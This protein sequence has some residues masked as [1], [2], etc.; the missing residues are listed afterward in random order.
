MLGKDCFLKGVY[1]I[2]CTCNGKYYIGST[3]ESFSK[4]ISHHVSL[5][6]ANKHKNAHMQRCFNKYG[7]G[8]FVFEILKVLKSNILDEEQVY[9]DMCISDEKC[10]NINPIAS[11]TPNLSKEVIKKRAETMRRKYA[12]GEMESNFKKGHIPWNKGKSGQYD[13]TYLKKPKTL[14]KKL[15]NSRKQMSEERRSKS[16]KIFAYSLYGD[17]LGSWR[18]SKDLEEWSL[19]KN[20]LLPIMSRFKQEYRL[21]KPFNFLSSQ[22]ITRSANS[23][24]PYKGIYFTYTCHIEEENEN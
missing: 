7:E 4:R 13:T 8:S 3:H 24:K 21:G 12:M 14:T 19:S 1:K 11:G 20:N 5:L 10:F 23:G 6:R 16:P 15:V 22:N 18:S 9:L 17:Y 2:R